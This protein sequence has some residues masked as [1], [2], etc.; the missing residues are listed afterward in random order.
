MIL[1]LI[2]FDKN[3]IY[4]LYTFFEQIQK[5]SNYTCNSLTWCYFQHRKSLLSI[6]VFFSITEKSEPDPNV[7][8]RKFLYIER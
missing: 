5:L 6:W 8:G 4:Y 7:D 3:S 1:N 2:V